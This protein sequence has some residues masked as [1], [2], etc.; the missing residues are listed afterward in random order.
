MTIPIFA[1]A[2]DAPKLEE[3]DRPNIQALSDAGFSR[4]EIR[5]KYEVTIVEL[6]E[7]MGW[8]CR[9]VKTGANRA[10][11]PPIEPVHDAYLRNLWDAGIHQPIVALRHMQAEFAREFDISAIRARMR[12]MKRGEA[13]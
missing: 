9:P 3:S 7:F 11:R 1:K 13:A 6:C 4:S 5:N 8:P 2:N 12:K 10:K